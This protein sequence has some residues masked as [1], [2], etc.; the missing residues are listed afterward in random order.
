LGADPAG[1]VLGP[2]VAVLLQRL[3]DAIGEILD[4]GDELVLSRL[5]HPTN[6]APWQRAADYSGARVRWAEIDIETCDLPSW[7]YETLV[8]KRTRL[9]AV[10]A[11][12]ESV[13]ARP[14][15]AAITRIAHDV[16]ALCVVDAQSAAP[17]VPLSLADL[18]AD[19]VAVSAQSWGGP[20][21]A[22]LAFANPELLESL[23][24]LSDEP[25]ATGAARLEVG[26]HVYPLLAG[27]NASVDYLASLDDFARGTRRE[28]LTTSLTAVAG[29]HRGLMANLVAELQAIRSVTVIGHPSSRV[30]ILGVTVRDRTAI[31]V[32]THLATQG[33]SASADP[34]KAGLFKRLGLAEVGGVVRLGLAHYTNTTELFRVADALAALK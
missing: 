8:T 2:N 12:S 18:G 24:S 23:P 22:A 33:I 15:V 11:A 29:H 26:A 30:P 17:F 1:V 34:A 19:V 13:G 6:V 4:E 9:V 16:G 25:D 31:D 20:P 14:D 27:V 3:A 10:T 7:Q 5:D 28:R 21:V 32:A